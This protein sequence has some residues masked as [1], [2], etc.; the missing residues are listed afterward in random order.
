[1]AVLSC[2]LLNTGFH[3]MRILCLDCCDAGGQDRT[4]DQ[5]AK[6]DISAQVAAALSW[7]TEA[8]VDGGFEDDPRS[9]LA[10]P[11]AEETREFAAPV[12]LPD[13]KTNLTPAEPQL[14]KAAWPADLA[15]F[16]GWWMAEP[17]LDQGQAEARLP[18]RGDAQADLL[19][20]VPQPEAEDSE[21][22]L[23]G[24]QG[25]L[26]DAFL[27]A[28]GLSEAK[29]YRASVLP[30]YMPVPDWE[31][32]QRMGLGQLA[33]HH[34]ALVRPKRMICFGG[35]ILPLLGHDPANS[36]ADFREFNHEGFTVPLLAARDLGALLERPRWRAALW[37]R[38]LD[39]T[40]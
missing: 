7:W 8:G 2:S 28:A 16:A 20:L 36:P 3:A 26:L 9:W 32:A 25:K 29:L 22:L 38:W 35:S 4:M 18:P 31:Q 19:I 11:E 33:G 12:I 30:R 40:A 37:Q 27:T 13:A 34:I 14:D 21:S 6:P 1:M 15:D 17:A 10:L 5:G 24:P 39:W 23:S